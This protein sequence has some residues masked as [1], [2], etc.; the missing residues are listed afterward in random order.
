MRLRLVALLVGVVAAAL[1]LLLLLP[2]PPP[3]L[4]LLLL[5]PPPLLLVAA[6][7][8]GAAWLALRPKRLIRSLDQVGY[9]TEPGWSRAQSASRT[10]KNRRAG[11]LL[12]SYP[13]GWFRLLGSAE[14]AR[15]EVRN[16]A[17]LGESLGA[18]TALPGQRK[19]EGGRRAGADRRAV[20]RAPLE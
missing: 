6:A 18:P 20:E 2:P 10:R 14:L 3:L 17:A 8:G 1:L 11:Q 13:N 4:L 5:L 9:L 19:R 7:G 15:G 12:P 16:V